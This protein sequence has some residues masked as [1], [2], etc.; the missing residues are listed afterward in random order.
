MW[1]FNIQV[2]NFIE[3][4][5]P[6]IILVRKKTKECV[7][8]DIA[9]QGDFR[10]QMKKDKKIEK[11]EDLRQKIIKLWGVQ[12][13]V[14]PII[15]GALGTIKDHLTSFLAM[16][17]VSLSFETIQKSS[18]ARISAYSEKGARDLGIMQR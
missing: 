9:V 4:R 8:I 16:V 5:R 2:D 10:T 3:A 15:I 12:I 17:G 18:L 6:D 11:Y 13:T 14:I 1:E 7:I